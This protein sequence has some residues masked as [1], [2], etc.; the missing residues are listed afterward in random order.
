[1]KRKLPRATRRPVQFAAPRVEVLEARDVPA[2]LLVDDDFAANTATKFTTI[3]AAVDAAAPGDLIRVNPG[4]YTEQVT[5]PADKDDLTIESKQNHKAIIEAPDTLTGTNAVVRVA[6]AEDVTL[7]GFT[8]TGPLADWGVHV[9]EGG[10]ATIRDNLIEDIGTGLA[11]DAQ[12]GAGVLIGGRFADGETPATATVDDNVIRDY[13]K[14]GIVVVNDGTEAVVTDNEVTGSGP[15]EFV[16]Q[17]GIQ[18]AFGASAVVADNEVSDNV[19]TGPDFEAAGIYVFDAGPVVVA[20]NKL[21]DNQD[22]ILLELASDVVVVGNRVDDS[23][24]D[25]IVVNL[26]SGV[27]VLDNRVDDS[28]RDGIVVEDSTGVVVALNRVTDSGRYGIY[29]TGS[30]T[31]NLILMNR[32]DDGGTADIFDD[33]TGT[34]TVIPHPGGNSKANGN[35][36]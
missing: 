6:G 12:T 11:D 5:V 20:D 17:N 7:S 24:L 10:S 1:M 14:A 16:A 26:S 35:G 3:Q 9:D 33:S 30:S 25:G 19:F 2:T 27:V 32:V 4:V 18:V 28:G 31:D 34:N 36:G 21:S 23:V 22:G 8:I 13:Q 29:V 15:N